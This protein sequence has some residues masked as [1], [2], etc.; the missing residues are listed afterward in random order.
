MYVLGLK[1]S[2]EKKEVF[3]IIDD[4]ASA[5]ERV[6]SNTKL[7]EKKAASTRNGLSKYC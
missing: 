1:L 6:Y 5:F 3:G 4:K 7:A 2:C